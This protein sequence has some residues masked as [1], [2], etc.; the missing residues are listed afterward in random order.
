M[1]TRREEK[2]PQR[3]QLLDRNH[4]HIV[5]INGD[6]ILL[7]YDVSLIFFSITFASYETMRRAYCDITLQTYFQMDFHVSCHVMIYVHASFVRLRLV[8]FVFLRYIILIPQ[9]FRKRQG[10]LSGF[11]L[12]K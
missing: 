5:L 10:G 2:L 8:V 4:I 3:F 9:S 7:P 6:K 1:S 11:P 12:E